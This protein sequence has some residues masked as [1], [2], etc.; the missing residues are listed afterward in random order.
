MD[1]IAGILVISLLALVFAVSLSYYILNQPNQAQNNPS[2]TPTPTPE[3]QSTSTGSV[4]TTTYGGTTLVCNGRLS[5]RDDGGPM[6]IINFVNI[7]NIGTATAYRVN[8]RI[9]AYYPDGTKAAGVMKILDASGIYSAFPEYVPFPVNI[10]PGQTVILPN[11]GRD[12]AYE[13]RG[14]IPLDDSIL[15]NY[16]IT[17]VW[18]SAP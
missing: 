8:L 11:S 7:T 17:P 18:S 14:D 3:T 13:V 16:T 4:T 5:L 6:F 2:P 15:G 12:G 10:E 1:K 9:Q